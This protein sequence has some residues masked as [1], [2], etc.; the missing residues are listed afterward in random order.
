MATEGDWNANVGGGF[1]LAEP[2]H[3]LFQTGWTH[4]EDS[5]TQTWYWGF[6]VPEAKINCFAYCWTH[7]NLDV[8]TGGLMIY[9][10]MKAQALACELFDIRAFNKMA[11]IVGDGS[12]IRFPNSMRVEVIEPLHHMRLTYDDPG[13]QTS[14]NVDIRATAPPLMRANNQHFEQVMKVTGDLVLRGQAYTVDCHNVRD[15][16]W[17]EP[18]PEDHAPLPPYTW[19]TG[20]FGDDFAFNLGAH[21]DPARGPEWAGVYDLP[22]ASIVKD[23]WVQVGG[24]QRRLKRASKITR[25]EFP[26]CRPLAHEIELE[27]TDG[28]IY[29]ISG[30]VVAQSCWSGWPNANVWLG[31][32]EWSWDEQHRLWRDAGSA[33]E[34]LYLAFRTGEDVTMAS[35]TIGVGIIGVQPERSWAAIA[36]IPAIQALGGYALK[37]LSTTRMESARAAGA[38]YGVAN[39]YDNHRDLV[40]DPDVDLVV[41]T[42]K[43]PAHYEL[44]N[45]ALD[46][47]KMVYCEWPLGN[48]L[49][50]AV[51]M[52]DKARSLGIRCAAG[53]QARAAPAV[54]Y[55]RDL[56][57]D[58]FVGEVLS[59]TLIGSGMAW[60]PVTD[61]ANAYTNTRANGATMLTIPV[62]HT[63]E[64]LCHCLGELA[65]VSATMTHGR[66]T[67]L[68]AE[69]GE[70][71]PMTSEDQIAFTGT[72]ES[73]AAI[74]VHYRG[75]FC[76]GTNMLWEIN[77]SEGDI[78]VTGMAG[79]LQMFDVAIAG[80]RGD[81]QTLE[82]MPVPGKYVWTPPGLAGPPLNVAQALVLFANDL[83][84]GN[85]TCPDFDDAVQRHRMIAAIERSA[86][87]GT[88]E[89]VR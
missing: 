21:D 40:N 10:G 82:A 64:G 79:H 26:L 74:A 25:R 52:A 44:V 37:A 77:G 53:T 46:A 58:G 72:L 75:G 36:T 9:Q 85:R 35:G 48:G 6:N 34:R 51:A 66:K 39:C 78:Q 7:P 76:R 63:M 13:R 71:L 45:A 65:E 83:R 68:N 88:R 30:E 50:E 1:G 19:V 70:T 61:N 20:V 28:R 80:G 4:S 73:G 43:V 60:G 14:V 59:T 3:E 15:R 22:A 81:A 17:G 31:L 12:L 16:S 5:L 49:D 89:T 41:V 69:S 42:V 8:V 62:G 2:R 33:V 47:G 29:A 86:A 38:A 27:D 23:G 57:R 11:P 84:D 56:I 54:N 32:V 87:N 24:E 18:R 55:I 67:F